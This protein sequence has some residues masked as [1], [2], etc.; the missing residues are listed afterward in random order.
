MAAT[1]QASEAQ[2]HFIESLCRER[3]TDAL[4]G[5]QR[6][7]LDSF[8]FAQLNKAQASRVITAL[9]E[10]PKAASPSRAATTRMAYWPSVAQGRYAVVD[11]ADQILKFYKVSIPA[12]GKWKGWLFLE[13]QASDELYRV[14]NGAKR[15]EI[16]DAIAVNPQE[17]M[18]RYG[19]EL[20]HCGHCGRTLTNELSREYGIGPVCR[21]KM[22]W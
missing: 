21:A 16:M 2:Q 22:G 5:R 4:N 14:S 10:L 6:D 3:D 11:P 20:G 7:W 1:E 17:A 19:Q 12:E 8:D 18:L 15:K 9:K 13:V